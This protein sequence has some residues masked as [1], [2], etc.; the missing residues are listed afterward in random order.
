MTIKVTSIEIVPTIQQ[1]W[2]RVKMGEEL[3]E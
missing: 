2:T 1:S 3:R